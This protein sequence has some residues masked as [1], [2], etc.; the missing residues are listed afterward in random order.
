MNRLTVPR[1]AALSLLFASI[2]LQACS[3]AEE[4]PDLGYGPIGQLDSGGFDSGGPGGFDAG[5][6]LPGVTDSG[7]VSPGAK[8]GLPCAVQKIVSEKC[9]A[10]HSDPPVGTFMALTT[11]AHWQKQ[12][13]SDPSK[14]YF[15]LSK[16]RI[17]AGQNP[18]PPITSPALTAD[19]KSTLNAWLDQGAPVSTESC[20]AVMTPDA[21]TSGEDID[22]TG[23]ECVRFTAH[24]Q[25]DKNAKFKVGTV[26]D[27]YWFF[28]FKPTWTG[29]VYGLT[30]KPIIDNKQVLHHWL[31]Y[32]E[33]IAD[34]AVE[35]TIGEHG[36]G[37]LIHG[38]APGGIAMDF[39][40]SGDV[41]F[42]LNADTNYGLEL[43]Y[44]SSD[45]N[46]LDASGAEI[47]F[48]RAKT[49]HIAAM[50][51]LGRD[52]GSVLSYASGICF[53]AATTW[54][55]TCKPISKEPIHIIFQTPHMHQT[56]RHMKSVINGPNGTRV[57]HDKPFDFNY[58]LTYETKETLMPGETITTTC[59]FSEPKCAGQSTKQEMCYNFVYA[60][61][62]G[63]LVDN[64]PEGSL[65]HGENV[66]LG[67]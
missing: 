51:W 19:E 21:G 17:N 25:G 48:Q 16:T 18:M 20:G 63:A 46:A 59:N 49:K 8:S 41:S 29:T 23:L 47:C 5:N 67:Q 39:R 2:S 61:P 44:N 4:G 34:G 12:G 7:V 3:E 64:M 62:K 50:S 24:A 35:K 31:L 66:C 53:D 42:E 52:Q 57:M 36:S 37:E 27:G 40:K 30:V 54:T 38:W 22:T 26:V 56:G 6:P 65:M 14:K 11:Q 15:E 10:C 45:P 55:G 33:K 43:H 58:Q 28:G 1:A 9:G 60:Y 13:T 32:K